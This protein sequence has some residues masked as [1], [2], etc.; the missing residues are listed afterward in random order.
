MSFRKTH[1]TDLRVVQAE[2]SPK[3]R[4]INFTPV[5]PGMIRFNVCSQG[6]T[7][8]DIIRIRRAEISNEFSNKIET[9][10]KTTNRQSVVVE[11]EVDFRGA[12]LCD[13]E[14]RSGEPV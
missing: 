7:N 4:V 10:A 14:I 3:H 2:T 6:I 13:F 9:E 8:N 5:N 11:L 1:V 12:L